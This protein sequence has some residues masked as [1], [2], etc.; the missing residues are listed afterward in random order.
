MTS[1]VAHSLL[2]LA[3]AYETRTSTE[4]SSWILPSSSKKII[5]SDE[6]VHAAANHAPSVVRAF[7]RGGTADQIN[8]LDCKGRH[9]VEEA[10]RQGDVYILE[11]LLHGRILPTVKHVH[12]AFHS[13][14]IHG[15]SEAVA[16]LLRQQAVPLDLNIWTDDRQ[17]VLHVAAHRGHTPVLRV[18]LTKARPDPHVREALYGKTPVDMANE[19]GAEECSKLLK[20]YEKTWRR[21]V[22]N[23]LLRSVWDREI[24]DSTRIGNCWLA[25]I[26]FALLQ[27]HVLDALTGPQ[28]QGINEQAY[29]MKDFEVDDKCEEEVNV[30]EEGD[31]PSVIREKIKRQKLA[32]TWSLK[33]KIECEDFFSEGILL[34]NQD[35]NRSSI[36]R[37]KV[38]AK[39]VQAPM[40]GKDEGQTSRSWLFL[41]KR[42]LSPSSFDGVPIE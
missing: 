33:A 36:S 27:S 1:N 5:T 42:P 4:L 9:A 18:L 24:G 19:A 39:K 21:H 14:V 7:L 31:F 10:A 15:H 41:R 12:R 38:L 13:A 20:D 30:H 40:P 16:L 2:Y 26:P 34:S 25:H 29:A 32:K 3:M 28:D 6:F 37:A 22:Y 35:S 11:L 17:T 8:V 23:V